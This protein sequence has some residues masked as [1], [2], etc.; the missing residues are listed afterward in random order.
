LLGNYLLNINN[1]ERLK[2]SY[3]RSFYEIYNK[4]I[5]D[6]KI[7]PI[8]SIDHTKTDFEKLVIEIYKSMHKDDIYIQQQ[9]IY[10]MS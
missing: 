8:K 5:D 10:Y 9:T 2:G 3:R 4:I 7:D 1:N 6:Y